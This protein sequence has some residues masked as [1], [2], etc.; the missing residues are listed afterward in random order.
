METIGFF[1]TPSFIAKFIVNAINEILISDNFQINKG[2]C[3]KNLKLLDFA[4]GQGT[5]L[6]EVYK[7]VFKNIKNEKEKQILFEEHLLKNIYGF[8][9]DANVLNLAKNNIKDLIKL[10]N[11]SLN[12]NSNLNLYNTD[13][14]LNNEIIKI[15]NNNPF[16]ILGTPPYS[17][18]TLN[19]KND[20]FLDE[21]KNI[22][23]K[24]NTVFNLQIL[25]INYAHY[26]IKN[27]TQGIIA[28]LIDDSFLNT[29]SHQ[30]MR[31]SLYND[32][33]LIYFINIQKNRFQKTYKVESSFPG[34]AGYT[35]AF[36]IKV[37]KKIAKQIKYFSLYDNDINTFEK[38]ESFFNNNSFNT[39]KWQEIPLN[40]NFSF[41]DNRLI[42]NESE[43]IYLNKNNLLPFAI[44][45]FTIINFHGIEK[46]N[47]SNIPIDSQWIFLTGENGKGKTS[48][49]KALT[50]GLY[51]YNGKILND[52]L[53]NNNENIPQI[54]IEY[55]ENKEV[56]INDTSDL[57]KFRQLEYLAAYGPF[58]TNLSDEHSE[59]SLNETY[60]SERPNMMNIEGK[61]KELQNEIKL[62]PFKDLIIN[63]LK[64]LLP[65]LK[66]IKIVGNKFKTGTEI[67]YFEKDSK[68]PVKFN[69]LAM[70]L[71]SIIGFIGDL[72][73]RLTKNKSI[74]KL[75]EITGIVL[76]D[77]FDNH[78]HPKWQRELVEKL[79]K[80][81]PRVQFIVSTHS[82]IP[83]LG[84]PPERTVIL[85]VNRTKEDGITIKRLAKLE[86]E[87]KYLLPNQLLTSDIFGLEN[88]ENIYLKDNE[89]DKLY[90]E[91]NYNDIEKNELLKKDLERRA[92]NKEIFPDDLFNE[93][94]L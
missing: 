66:D 88:I 34:R 19:N 7:F 47:I 39:I 68:D 83:L 63:L 35:I 90:S 1:Y 89:L 84:A 82:P 4:T 22:N 52:L 94:N 20:L 40:S 86:K 71:R 33:D 10:E 85:N 65:T 55:I 58:R 81:F 25:F 31:K 44:K 24:K 29:I 48:I 50:I 53:I 76:I 32:F 38:I 9:I 5:Y 11:L 2:L 78:L 43:N 57:D 36:F 72:F 30:S 18:Q 16:I 6:N 42:K 61:L 59:L 67:L 70:G 77:E 75:E 49:L 14:L 51:D 62:K 8:D 64:E 12:E 23:L 45:Q 80:L 56:F 17:S 92:T 73:L 79:T 21:Y 3:D 26:K 54:S 37:E 91:D 46:I 13:T 69:E 74:K 41:I 15:N 87:L 60:F 28:V 27:C 93:K